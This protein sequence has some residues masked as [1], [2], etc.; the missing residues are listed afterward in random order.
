MP[1]SACSIIKPDGV[2]ITVE[3]DEDHYQGRTPGFMHPQTEKFIV[4]MDEFLDVVGLSANE[5][6]L[7]V[8]GCMT[9]RA[10]CGPSGG[11]FLEQQ[12]SVNRAAEQAGQPQPDPY[13]MQQA[14][15]DYAAGRFQNVR[16][17]IDDLESDAESRT[18]YMLRDNT[19]GLFYRE[20]LRGAHHSYLTNWQPFEEASMW[21]EKRD[22]IR[23]RERQAE[24]RQRRNLEIVAFTL[25]EIK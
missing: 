12:A 8:E 2:K 4:D 22:L 3:S 14:S 21:V 10:E 18:V 17:I 24:G 13:V 11:A 19:S 6:K 23:I 9:G 5:K 16:E 20:P 1:G 15:E 25:T 7:N